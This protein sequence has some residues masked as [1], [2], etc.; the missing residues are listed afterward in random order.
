[1]AKKPTSASVQ[2]KHTED[3]P[4]S[5]DHATFELQLIYHQ[6]YVLPPGSIEGILSKFLC[7]NLEITWS[8]YVALSNGSPPISHGSLSS[9]H[10]LS[11]CTSFIG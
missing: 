4:R 5:I 7:E 6:W 9:E 8:H 2:I 1:M 3:T 10:Y 11:S